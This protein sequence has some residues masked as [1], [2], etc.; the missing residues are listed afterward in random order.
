[1]Q[2]LGEAVYYVL[3]DLSKLIYRPH[4]TYYA[5]ITSTELLSSAAYAMAYTGVLVSLA[6]LLFNR[7]DF[8]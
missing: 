2:W 1:V 6:V 4:A 8:R 7:R 3:P 5:A